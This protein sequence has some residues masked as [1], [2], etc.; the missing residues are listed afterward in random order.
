MAHFLGKVKETNKSG[1]NKLF[2][3]KI[4]PFSTSHPEGISTDAIF[5]FSLFIFLNA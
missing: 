3:F 5:V 1:V 2:S 4:F